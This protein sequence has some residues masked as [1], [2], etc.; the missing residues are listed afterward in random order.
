MKPERYGRDRAP[1]APASAPEPDT[2][3]ATLRA[4]EPALPA[5]PEQ[6]LDPETLADELALA[7][8]ADGQLPHCLSE[9]APPA[10]PEQRAALEAEAR[11]AR[12]RAAIAK[13]EGG[14]TLTD[15]E[16]ADECYAIDP[17]SNRAPR[18][19]ERAGDDTS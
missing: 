9:Q 16:F 3:D 4:M 6:L 1:A 7:D 12:G 17:L 2:L 10:T 8:I 11:H 13:R 14:G 18:P 15:A 5:P 19:R